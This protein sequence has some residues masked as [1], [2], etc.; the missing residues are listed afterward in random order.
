MLDGGQPILR[1]RSVILYPR[2]L[3][4]A[5]IFTLSGRAAGMSGM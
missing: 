5:R 3:I 2:F 1:A 4:S